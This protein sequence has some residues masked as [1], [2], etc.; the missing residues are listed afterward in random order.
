VT[1]RHSRLWT[2][3]S[4]GFALV[5]C[6]SLARADTSPLA[7][8][9]QRANGTSRA[10]GVHAAA[11]DHTSHGR[12]HRHTLHHRTHR[13]TPVLAQTR[14]D[15]PRSPLPARPKPHRGRTHGTVPSQLTHSRAPKSHADRALTPFDRIALLD[16]PE[17]ALAPR[18]N[19]GPESWMKS[20]ETGRGPPRGSPTRHSSQ[21]PTRLA[22][23]ESPAPGLVSPDLPHAPNL[24]FDPT[25]SSRTPLRAFACSY[26]ARSVRDYPMFAM[27]PASRRPHVRRPEGATTCSF[28]PSIGGSP[29]P[30]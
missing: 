25:P 22:V 11:A 29:C 20:L 21:P 15:V 27:G 4:A 14:S 28:M 8:A 26:A 12:H 9:P 2:T 23:V 5:V 6:V 7:S 3:L 10:T 13:V 16:M 24:N 1:P 30:A 17:R 18:T 19:F